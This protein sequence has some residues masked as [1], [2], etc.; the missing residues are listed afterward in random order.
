MSDYYRY[1]N[2]IEKERRRRRAVVALLIVLVLLCAAAGYFWMTRQTDQKPEP[3]TPETA[4]PTPATQESAVPLTEGTQPADPQRLLPAID[5]TVWDTSTPVEQTIDFDY[6]NTDARM[7]ALPALGEVERSHFDTVTFLGDS[8]TEGMECYATGYQNAQIRAYRGAGPDSV[9]NNVT[10]ED[11][12]RHVSEAVF[13]ATV[14]TQPDALYILFGT[15]SMVN[16][17]NEDKFIAYYERMIDMFHESLPGVPIY[18]QS[19]P[20]VQEWV[21]DTKPGLDNDRIRTVNNLLA[22]MALRKG[23]YFVN[24]AEVLNYPDGSQIDDY[25]VTDGIHL[26]P[27]AYT[28]WCNYLATHT[29]WDRR[30]QYA[31]TNPLYILGT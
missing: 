21:K 7:A 1:R 20:G 17:N 22:N 4:L 23:C 8:I 12:V 10:T 11:K 2:Q 5:N 3:M 14:A 27:S 16:Q 30:N 26:Q 29:A 6:L 13:D 31:G 24:I 9:V 18:V 25:A 28:A 19:I 15:N